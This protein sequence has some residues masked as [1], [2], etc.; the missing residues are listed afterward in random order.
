MT[1][2]EFAYLLNVSPKWVQN[3]AVVLGREFRYDL[4]TAR[5]VAVA[6]A[7][8]EALE[9]PIARAYAMAGDVLERYDGSRRPVSVST[10]DGVVDVQVDVYR[11]LAAVYTG[12]SRMR[13]NYAPRLRGR[14]TAERRDPI[15]AA[16][17][18]GLDLTLLAANLRRTPAERLRQL[19][20][21]VD[22][23]R[24]VR[25]MGQERAGTEPRLQKRPYRERRCSSE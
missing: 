23:R 2:S 18:Y 12:L 6:R 3:T 17:E 13:T 4:P 24:R 20:A 10:P 16:A 11:I 1:L 15:R 9:L 22:F 25:R 14:P 7:L 5:R 8:A 21:M 19:D